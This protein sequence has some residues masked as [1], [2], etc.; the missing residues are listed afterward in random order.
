MKINALNV[1]SN[2]PDWTANK[3]KN[4]NVSF[5]SFGGAMLNFPTAFMQTIESLGYMGSFLVQDALGMTLPRVLTGF[6]RD[7]KVTGEYN[8]QEGLEVLGREGMTGPYMM[9]VAPAMLY[10]AGHFCKST[11][12]NTA[13]IK[14][15]NKNFKAMLKDSRLNTS[16]KNDKEKFKQFFYRYNIEKI[17]KENVKGD[18]KPQD[19]IEYILKEFETYKTTKDKKTRKTAL[20]NIQ[21]YIDSK[22][23]ETSPELLNVNKL[24][25]GEGK[26]TGTFGITEVIEAIKDYGIDAIERNSEF[27][28]IDEKAAENIKNNFAAKRL[29]LNAA[30]IGATLGGLS[31]IPKLYVRGNTSPGAKS[32]EIA[33]VKMNQENTK[34]QDKTTENADTE[35]DLQKVAFKGK[36]INNEGLISKIGAYITNTIPDNIHKLFEYQGKNFTKT[37]FACL[38]TFGL[39]LPR[40]KKAWDRAQV[41]ENG[42]RDMTEIH[43]ILLRDTVSTLAVVFAVPMFTKMIVR[44]FEDSTGF[45]LTNRASANKNF[46]QR[47]WDV[48][49]P[50][51]NLEV[52]SMDDLDA[53]YGDI[54]NKTKL[55][56]FAKFIDT[57]GGDLEKILS[58]SEYASEVFNNKTFTLDSIR[59]KTKTEKN[60]E[61]I[62]LFNKFSE[63]DNKLI[64]KLMK[65]TGD[66]SQ[67]KIVQV[68]RSMNS[69]PGFISTVLISPILLGILLPKLTYYFTRKSH[70]KFISETNNPIKTE[71]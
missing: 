47:V 43:E 59:H 17:Y 64:E 39:L 41:H 44:S 26:E 35:N 50:Y 38:A 68:A 7:R 37:T 4:N 40:G 3:R 58:R 32:L 57:K 53:I 28:S 6:T 24:H 16:I 31:V 69:R 61:I 46:L 51:S 1:H 15:L 70:E 5:K 63:K 42:K 34:N 54:N 52:F 14:Q 36:G 8:I 25:L 11:N 10:L 65:G 19:A 60:K 18:K 21:K 20:A 71:A 56:N 67:N 62:E 29:F 55:Q 23:V 2:R 9:V 49:W 66:I 45:I 27:A 30:N 13:L 48:L 22:M 33:K 12:T